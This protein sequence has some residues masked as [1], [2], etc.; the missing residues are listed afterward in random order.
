MIRANAHSL[1]EKAVPIPENVFK[2]MI[3][4][5]PVDAIE[6]A[7]GLPTESRAKLA[8]FCYERR[9]LNQLGLVIASTCDRM[10]LRRCFGAA[11]DIIFKQTR[12]IEKTLEDQNKRQQEATKITLATAANVVA[13]RPVFDFDDDGE[14]EGDL[15]A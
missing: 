12:D 14:D 2:E 9:H 11:G 5:E 1:N 13:L 3:S 7:K 6:V 10:A 4:A 8:K 15:S